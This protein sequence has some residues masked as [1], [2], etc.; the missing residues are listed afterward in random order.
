MQNEVK[1]IFKRIPTILTERLMLR[2]IEKKD[3]PDIYEY[4]KDPK[5]SEFLLW[6]PHPAIDITKGYYKLI[7]RKYKRG[8]LYEWALINTRDKKMIGTCGFTKL[9][10]IDNSAEVGYVI[11]PAYWGMGF[12]TEA[13]KRVLEFG[14]D[15]LS[16]ERIEARYM[17]E[18]SASR[19]VM[20][21][22][23]MQFEGIMKHA[24]YAKGK[25]R[26]VGLC[27]IT[28]DEYKELLKNDSL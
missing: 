17:A 3:I 16:L 1:R 19:R 9:N 27:A 10:L 21:K 25:Y 13:L 26:D 5:T 12:A 28:A 4:S 20:E 14:F 23:H 6:H 7:N 8:A 24:V 22:C 15:F 18:N 11:A 2:R